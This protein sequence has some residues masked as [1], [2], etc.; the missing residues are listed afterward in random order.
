MYQLREWSMELADGDVLCSG[1]C[2]GHPRFCDGEMIYTSRVMEVKVD[3]VG[4]M[5]HV[6]TYSGSHYE[7]CFCDIREAAANEISDAMY[8]LGANLDINECLEL[9]RQAAHMLTQRLAGVLRAGE[10]Y[11]R[12]AGG[13]DAK[14]AYFKTEKGTVVEIPVWVHVG[15]FEDSVLVEKAGLCDWRYFPKQISIEPY[16]WSD[17]LEAV[18]LENMGDD[19]I[20]KGTNRNIPCKHGEVTVIKKDEY[21]GEGLLSPD[22]VNGKSLLKPRR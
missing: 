19:F 11:V 22:S 7:M 12:M 4:K 18:Y 20:F 6:R 13:N 17:G 5:V 14:E 21:K 1:D 9:K 10:L 2:Y 16:H 15:T 8:H 3:P